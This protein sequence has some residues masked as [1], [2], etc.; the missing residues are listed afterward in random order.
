MQKKYWLILSAFFLISSCNTTKKNA[1]SAININPYQFTGQKKVLAEN[2]AVVSA[3]P[4]ASKVG[5]EILK[6]G[7]NISNDKTGIITLQH[8][9]S[10]DEEFT[11]GQKIRVM[12][13]RSERSSKLKSIYFKKKPDIIILEF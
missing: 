11:E 1:A 10:I 9:E 8:L 3:H 5:V 13:L 4:L 2:G 6:M 7:G 12:H